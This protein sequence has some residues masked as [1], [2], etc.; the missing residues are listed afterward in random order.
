MQSA[1]P[2][3]PSPSPSP[4]P[5][6]A[7]VVGAVPVAV[8]ALGFARALAVAAV[9]GALAGTACAG[10]LVALEEVTATRFAHPWLLAGL[11]L[12]GVLTA[13]IYR[14]VGGASAKGNNL[15]LNEIHEPGG[16]VPLRMA[17]LVLGA[18]LL[19]HLC[20]G[21]AGR[22]GTGVQI[23]G[24]LAGGVRKWLRLG[25][26]HQAPLLAAG[27][28]A[29]FGAVFGTPLAGAVFALEVLVR[30]RFHHAWLATCLVAALVG[31]L[32]CTAWGVRHANFVPLAGLAALPGGLHLGALAQA[33][34]VG[35]ACGGVARLFVV[36]THGVGRGLDRLAPAWWLK[37]IVG[38]VALGA[39][40]LALGTDAYLGLSAANPDPTAPSLVTL[41]SLN[42]VSPWA[43][44]FK[45]ACTAITVGAGFKGGEVTP[46]FFMGAA[47]GHVLGPLL[48]MPLNL[49]VALG[50]VA[51]FSG[52]S[53]TPLACTLLAVELFGG[54][55][56]G[57]FAVACLASYLSSGR[58]GIYQ[59]QR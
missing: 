7:P 19:T 14:R 26:E 22:E 55:H 43:W 56:A 46:L 28:A 32:T 10:F 4:A 51:V 38:G 44:A 16:G 3:S 45:L 40:T 59:A 39:L 47:L 42:E 21:S 41:F 49:G 29:G 34:L 23:G 5:L 33:A 58:A 52:A 36:A 6:P 1:Q 18:T 48:G 57:L 9:V 54:S 11:P 50:F 53:K 25:M 35:L 12:A 15:I 31:D 27:V 24:A 13:W 20:G 2:S 37:P 8:V 30:G 17:P